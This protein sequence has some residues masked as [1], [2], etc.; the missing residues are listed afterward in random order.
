MKG[1]PGAGADNAVGMEV[2]LLL[3]AE[4]GRTSGGSEDAVWGRL[5]EAGLLEELLPA[6]DVRVSL[7]H[8]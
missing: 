5:E 3:E 8:V 6:E 7:A 2:M 1:A 4:G